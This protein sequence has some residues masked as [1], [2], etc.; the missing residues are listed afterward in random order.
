MYCTKIGFKVWKLVFYGFGIWNLLVS[1]EKK[2]RE[3]NLRTSSPAA[4]GGQL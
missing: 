3:D 4:R 1:L 2:V